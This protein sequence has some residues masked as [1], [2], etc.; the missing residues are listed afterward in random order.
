VVTATPYLPGVEQMK[1][2]FPALQLTPDGLVVPIRGCSP[3][4]VLAECLAHGI[5]VTGSSIVYDAGSRA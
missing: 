1:A 4:S 3:E 5:Q 2:Q